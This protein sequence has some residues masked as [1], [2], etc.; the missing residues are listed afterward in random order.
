MRAPGVCAAAGASTARR[1]G[2]GMLAVA[3]GVTTALPKMLAMPLMK[4][5]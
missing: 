1:A 2:V 5:W 3:I 4:I